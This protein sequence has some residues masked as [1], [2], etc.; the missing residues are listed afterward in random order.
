GFA[1]SKELAD[2]HIQPLEF[3]FFCRKDLNWYGLPTEEAVGEFA[4]TNFDILLCMNLEEKNPLTYITARSKASFKVGL[5]SPQN[6]KYLDVML[7]LDEESRN[8]EELAKQILHY[9]D[10]IR[11]E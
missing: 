11:Y 10:N 7:S 1:D 2:F 4:D 6:A 9:L 8:I 3:S 5:Y